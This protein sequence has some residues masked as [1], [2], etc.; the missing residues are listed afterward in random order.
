MGSFGHWNLKGSVLFFLEVQIHK[1][2]VSFL[3][4]C[5][6]SNTPNELAILMAFLSDVTVV[7]S[8]IRVASFANYEILAFC[9]L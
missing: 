6:P 7:S 3:F 9:P 4:N 1:A 2:F 5:K 8:R